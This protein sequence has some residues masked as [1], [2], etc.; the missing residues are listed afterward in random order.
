M[1]QNYVVPREA[2]QGS[3]DRSH[4][5]MVLPTEADDL[6]P[7]SFTVEQILEAIIADDL[8]DGISGVTPEYAETNSDTDADWHE[9]QTED[10][11]WI[12]LAIGDPVVRTPGIPLT[13][14]AD[15]AGEENVQSDWDETDDT[16]DEY[17]Q[18]K[19]TIPA[20]LT[21]AQVKT[22]YENNADTNEFSDVEQT[23][24]D[25]VEAEAEKN[26]TLYIDPDEVSHS[27]DVISLD[28]GRSYSQTSDLYNLV[29][30]FRAKATNTG[31]VVL[32]VDSVSNRS[33][34]KLDN[35]QFAAGELVS[36]ELIVAAFSQQAGRFLSEVGD[37]SGG[38]DNPEQ[39]SSA[40]K[41]AWHGN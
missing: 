18:N 20:E 16:E 30:R 9:T 26:K 29:L 33:L 19:P 28:T 25:D 12:R 10:D 21:D 8:P 1:A 11:I 2:S 5:I 36:G 39:V 40:E 24:L 4:L 22:K 15:A 34:R 41:T 3:L 32:A 13:A 37:D 23:K 14:A 17:I 38:E 31:N 6:T 7:E 27:G 35:T